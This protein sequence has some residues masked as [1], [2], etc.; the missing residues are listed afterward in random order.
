M[1][2]LILHGIFGKSGENWMGWLGDELGVRGFNV[3]MPNLPNADH[4]D[5]NEWLKFICNIIDNNDNL[6]IVGHSLGVTSALDYIEQ[7]HHKI[8][9]L[10]SVSGFSQD[11]G[12]ELNSYFL[13]QKDIYSNKVNSNLEKAFVYYGDNDPYVTQEALAYLADKLNVKPNI[14]KNGGHLNEAAGY[15]EFPQLL[16]DILTIK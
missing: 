9:A 10:F 1:N 3:M 11:Y 4:P 12:L 14:I 5:R 16:N 8:K 13:K 6:I 2:V 15:T 7:S